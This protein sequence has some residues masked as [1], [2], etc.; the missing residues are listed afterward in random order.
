[1]QGFV[2]LKNE[3]LLPLQKGSNIAIIGPSGFDHHLTS[4]YAG[5]SGEG[6]CWPNADEKCIL[7]IADAIAQANVGG[8]TNASVGT[9][10]PHVH[11]PETQLLAAAL[12]VA[13]AADTVVLALGVIDSEG[14]GHDRPDM[15]L[16]T[17]QETLA[18]A[19]LRLNK[20]TLLI[21][22]N[23]GAVSIDHLVSGMQ[24][25]VE[26]F[27]PA[28]NAR[29][30]AHLLFG[31]RNLWGK[32]PVTYYSHNYSQGGGGLPPQPMNQYSMAASPGRTYRYYRGQPTFKFGDGLSLTTFNHT[33]VC[34]ESSEITC[35]CT[36]KN[37][38]DLDGD[39]VVL[40]FDALSPAIRATVGSRHPVPFKRLL[41]FE[42][43]SLIVGASTTIKFVLSKNQLALTTSSGDKKL[44]TGRHELI[45]S[46]GNGNDVT[47][48]VDL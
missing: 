44:Y 43:V 27:D 3:G 18:Q 30:L 19:V 17:A 32:L 13:K 14:E 35:S 22:T 21:L 28:H 10:L 47:V 24:A 36:V 5:G 8:T 38:G 16:S 20:P 45:F 2:L 9:Q 37:T 11:T 46:R 1:V 15:N 41:D 6:G 23:G 42:R 7:T 31:E 40:V 33:C 34:D 25:I 29:E 4:D 12:E 39:E 26:S 48:F